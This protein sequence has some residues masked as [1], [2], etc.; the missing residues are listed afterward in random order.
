MIPV[1]SVVTPGPGRAE[2]EILRLLEEQG[3]YDPSSVEVVR[4][5]R[6][7]RGDFVSRL[8]FFDYPA[9]CYLEGILGC[10]GD[11]VPQAVGIE[12]LV[13]SGREARKEVHDL[14][15]LCCLNP[16]RRSLLAGYGP[17]GEVLL[18]GAVV[19]FKSYRDFPVCYRR[20]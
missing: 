1:L 16:V 8:L 20:L 18:A 9:P 6:E 7:A 4:S 11:G 3:T 12:V 13:V 5:F 17:G 14:G 2:D 15:N 19:R 10:I